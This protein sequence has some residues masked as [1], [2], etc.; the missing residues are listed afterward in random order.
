MIIRSKAPLRLGLAGG[1][2][3]VSP[4]CDTF[5]GC[6]L[7]ATINLFTYCTIIPNDSGVV[8]FNAIDRNESELFDSNI[9]NIDYNG[10]LDL[11]KGVYNY[12]IN[13]FNTGPLSFDLTTT[14]DAPAGSGLGT[15]STL[16]VC[17][18][19]AFVEWLNLPLGEY[20]IAQ[21]AFQ[22]ERV[23]LK[24]SG[25]KQ[26]QYSATFGGFNF[27]EFYSDNRVIVNPLRLKSEII[28]ELEASALLY[29][30]GTSRES[31]KIIEDQ[32]KS[33]DNF[34]KLEGMHE[35]KN[36][37]FLIKEYLLK[38]QYY[39]FYNTMI[40]AWEAKKKTSN[41]V[42]NSNI[43]LIYEKAISSGAYCGKISGAGGGGFMLLFVDPI[44]RNH[45]INSLNEFKGKF[46][47]FK[48]IKDGATSW[49]VR[50]DN[51]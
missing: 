51:S 1:G 21:I 39:K 38:G 43:D 4:Y 30:T 6:V 19:Q 42:S 41:S 24:L 15:S 29:F 9:K 35:I 11:H 45:V 36:D 14:S 40:H 2:T 46:V 16:V 3:D 10:N 7:N 34:D 47:D 27:M 48:F 31:S 32:I 13:N 25:G 8:K 33:L 26:D 37:A 17:I 12:V 22:I 49:K 44:R 28:Y 50:N 5:G 20:E 18:L 23:E